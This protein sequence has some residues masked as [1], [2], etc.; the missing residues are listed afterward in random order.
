LDEV[1]EAATVSVLEEL[2][3]DPGRASV[4]NLKDEIGKLQIIR[5]VGL[6]K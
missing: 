2:K 6:S 3:S 5:A 1:I 4:D